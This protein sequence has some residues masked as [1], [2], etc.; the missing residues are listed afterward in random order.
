MN[1][2]FKKIIIKIS[3][4]FFML[5]GWKV[6]MRE[7]KR[8]A[9]H[10]VCQAK[11]PLSWHHGQKPSSSLSPVICLAWLMPQGLSW[12]AARSSGCWR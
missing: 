3:K 2:E 12:V 1:E 11:Q 7:E 8:S 5:G 6:G 4:H 9:Q 10:A